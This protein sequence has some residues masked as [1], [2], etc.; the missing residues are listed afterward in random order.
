MMTTRRK[1]IT[2]AVSMVCA[3]TFAT[4]ALAASEVRIAVGGKAL[5]Y[6][7]PLS[8]AEAKGYFKDEGVNVKIIDF[9][10][11][12]K[13]LQAVVGGSADIV[14]GAFEHTI[15]MQSKGQAM[16][17]F[18][19]QGRAPQ[20]AFVISKKTMPKF[21]SLKDLKGKK[22]GVTAPGSSSNV[23]GNYVLSS[24]G[25]KPTE[26]SYV[27]VGAGAGAVAAIR[28]GQIDAGCMLDPVVATLEKDNLITIAADSR[29]VD[30]SDKIFGGPMVA[31]CLYAKDS[32]ITANKKE[33]QAIT[34]A[35]VRA[36]KWLSTATEEDI[37]KTVPE[38]YFMGNKEIYIKGF[39][40]NR[41]ALSVDGKIPESAP[42]VS[43]KALQTVNPKLA[44]FKPDFKAVYTNEFVDVAHNK[45]G[46]K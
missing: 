31:G 24:A 13:A 27:G 3:A 42:A 18:V 16:R 17:A 7:L 9:Q 22:I 26:V 14:S 28:A 21:K 43:F 2:A 30:E 37:V 25:I 5:Y 34:N 29:I 38:T 41:P 44:S 40:K 32:Y 35:M 39:I 1:M 45:F 46:I 23:F 33:I 19:L 20:L 10:G 15:S 8:V 12:S 6:Y 11:G 36:A 4:S